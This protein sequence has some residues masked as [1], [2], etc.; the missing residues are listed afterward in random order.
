MQHCPPWPWCCFW[1]LPCPCWL[2]TPNWAPIPKVYNLETE[3]SMW[4]L[5]MGML[6][7]KK[8]ERQERK[9]LYIPL[10]CCFTVAISWWSLVVVCFNALV[11]IATCSSLISLSW[12]QKTHENAPGNIGSLEK[13]SCMPRNIPIGLLRRCSMGTLWSKFANEK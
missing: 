7:A 6:Q 8:T 10:N 12:K 4:L 9:T 1:G 5:S 2:E 3:Y 13:L 11:I